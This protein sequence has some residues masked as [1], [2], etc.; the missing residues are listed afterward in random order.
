M[1]LKEQKIEDIRKQLGAIIENIEQSALQ[2]AKLHEVEL[3]VFKSLL[4]L[5]LHLLNYYIYTVSE[6]VKLEGIPKDREGKQMKHSGNYTRPYRS[7]FGELGIKRPK[8]YSAK[9]KTNYV[10][11]KRLGLPS[12]KYSYILSDWL[13]YGAVDLDY[14]ESV[15]FMERILGQKLRGEQSRRQTYHLSKEVA[16]YYEAK[17]WAQEEQGNHLSVGFDG[18]GVPI[19]RMETD[20]AKESVGAR[21]GR[22]KK[23]GVKKEATVSVSST[24]SPRTRTSSEI[25]DSLFKVKD[26]E[27]LVAPKKRH[28]WHENKH[29]RAFLSA[30]EKAINYGLDNVLKRDASNN[31]PIIVLIDGDRGLR[32]GVQKIAK[33][34]GIEDR[35]KAY[36]LDFIHVLEY[37]WKVANAYKGEKS[38]EREEWVK[39]QALLLLEGKV[40]QVIKEWE[41]ISKLKKYSV[42]QAYN[43]QRGITYFTNHKDMMKYNQY[44]ATGYPITT[45]A[46]ESACGHFVKSRM[47]RNAMHWGKKGAQEMLNIRAIKK[48]GDWDD[49]TTKFIIKEQYEL[50][51]M[52]A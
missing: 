5:G 28:K 27:Q 44:L 19:I 16:S 38:E 50:Y 17:E 2:K 29:T 34:K 13:S 18:K 3:N 25:L 48:N 37:I 22:G 33:S 9:D 10:L 21:L 46:I 14:A 26:N 32:N 20:R 41:K 40:E 4:Q 8:Y 31:K 12:G 1:D 23:K 7:V 11:D 47:E 36:I 35:I 15:R 6:L 30:K 45:G 52:A 39:Q 24:F 49:Y 51:N 43:I 42:S